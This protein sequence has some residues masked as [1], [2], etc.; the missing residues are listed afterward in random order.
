M[1]LNLEGHNS[2]TINSKVTT[3]LIKFFFNEKFGFFGSG[4]SQLWIMGES[5]GEDVW[6]MA[7][8]TCVRLHVT[9]DV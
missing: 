6:I 8:V 3:I 1:I 2:F 9:C 5:A 7:L 4:T